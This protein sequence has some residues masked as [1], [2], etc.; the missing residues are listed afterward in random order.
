MINKWLKDSGLK[1]NNNKAEIR[2]FH[3]NLNVETCDNVDGVLVNTS[4][5]I[6]V[7]GV[8]FDSRLQ[9]CKQ[10]SNTIKRAYKLMHALKLIKKC[11][12][13]K[14][15]NLL[16]TSNFYSILCYNSE[17]WHLP[18]LKANLKQN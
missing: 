8:E 13:K 4:D 12:T 7:L 3:K 18:M 9:W 11:F 6:N 15:L 5:S 1:V 17:I 14:E 10:V 16:I 2:T